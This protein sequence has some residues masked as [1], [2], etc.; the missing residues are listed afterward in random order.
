MCGVGWSGVGG[1]GGGDCEPFHRQGTTILGNP[2]Q[3]K[4]GC[5][6]C[7]RRGGGVTGHC[8]YL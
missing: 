7:R 2:W 8:S 5:Q 6:H 1:G 3:G 4:S